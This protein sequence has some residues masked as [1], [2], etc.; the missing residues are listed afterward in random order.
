MYELEKMESYLRVNF[1]FFFS[2][3]YEKRIYWAAV[4]QMLINAGVEKCGFP[5]DAWNI[6]VHNE[7]RAL[8]NTCPLVTASYS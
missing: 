1:F 7:S 8:L 2:S 5:D 4:S 6:P 3:S